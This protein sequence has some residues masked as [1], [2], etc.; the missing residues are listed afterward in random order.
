[1]KTKKL[2][3]MQPLYNIKHKRCY[4]FVETYVTGMLR[5]KN[6]NGKGVL[7][8]TKELYLL[9]KDERYYIPK[10]GEKIIDGSRYTSIKYGHLYNYN[11]SVGCKISREDIERDDT[12][13]PLPNEALE[14]E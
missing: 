12:R 4:N 13:F 14:S 7:Y 5:V 6:Q 2:E 8:P 11:A 3:L 10:N 9:H 1:M